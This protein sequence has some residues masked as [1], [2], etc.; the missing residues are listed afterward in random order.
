MT[1]IFGETGEVS[2]VTVIE[3]G[4]CIVVQKKTCESDGYLAVQV[5]FVAKAARKVNKPA[6]GHFRKAKVGTYRYLRELRLEDAE[7]YE[8]GQEIRADIFAAGDLVDV[9]GTSRGKGFAGSIERHGFK[10]G[11]MAH[12]SKYHRGPGSLQSRAAARVFKGRKLPGRHGGA[13]VTVQNLKVIKVDLERNLLLIRGAVPGAT[14]S[15]VAVR[16]AVKS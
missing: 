6:T 13:R 7:K 16:A 9:T 1:Q 15:L 5:A 3:A 2:P 4:P 10:R 11:P 12:G 8:V 14:G